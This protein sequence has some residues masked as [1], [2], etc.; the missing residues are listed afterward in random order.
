MGVFKKGKNWYI[1]Y[2]V[3]GRRKREK[4]GPNKKQARTVLQKRKVQ[5]A[6]GKFLDIRRHQKVKFEDM[7]E[8]YMEAYSRPN[9]RSSA[10]D[11]TSLKN[12]TGFFG[13]K[14]LHEITSLDIEKYK[15]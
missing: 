15:V 8:T 12:L 4:V 3:N 10:R 7:G 1:D 6:E 11:E 13:G 5:I 14:Y 2:Y 9:K